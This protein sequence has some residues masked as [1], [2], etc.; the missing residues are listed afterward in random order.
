MFIAGGAA[1]LMS[2]GSRVNMGRAAFHLCGGCCTRRPIAAPHAVTASFQSDRARN[3]ARLNHHRSRDSSC[4]DK[5]V[6][7]W[8]QIP[9]TEILDAAKPMM[10]IEAPS[11][12]LSGRQSCLNLFQ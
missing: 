11:G 7:A 9:Q 8:V 4:D 2:S 1:I 5:S 3:F 12:G 10:D 6:S